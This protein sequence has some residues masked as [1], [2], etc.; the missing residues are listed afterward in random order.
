MKEH[1]TQWLSAYLDGE[2]K[3]HALQRVEGH[4]E[5]CAECRAELD[6]LAALRELLQ[7]NPPAAGLLPA[8]Q[9]AARVALR[10]PRH[11]EQPLW[12]GALTVG[13][14]LAP[15]GLVG[16][17]AFAQAVFLI[18]GGILLALGAGLGGEGLSWLPAS[19]GGGWLAVAASGGLNGVG[20]AVL[21]LLDS[22]GLL[23]WGFVL[24]LAA[25]AVIGLSCWSWLAAW[26]ARRR[27]HQMS[28]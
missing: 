8:E 12:R 15:V 5:R 21:C 20:E 4:L 13:W 11:Q 2:L 3:G 27:H 6:S 22:G 19:Q 7:E 28:V 16:A 18:A 24:N 14:R 17:W 9:F 25:T 1:V 10:L 23:G 26:W